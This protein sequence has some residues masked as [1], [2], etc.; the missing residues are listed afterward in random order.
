M[1]RLLGIDIEKTVVRT[2]IVRTAYRKTFVEAIG[3]A[4]IEEHG[5]VEAALRAALLGA[6]RPDACAVALSGERTLYRRIDL[7]AAAAKELE[8]VLGFEIE[9]TVPFEMTDA[10]FDHRLLR[11]AANS[12]VIPVLA[13]IARVEDVREPIR[14]VKEAL[15]MEPERVG[16]GPL[17]LADL[18]SLVPEL[19]TAPPELMVLP[20]DG[21][22]TIAIMDLADA[23]SDVAF[24]VGG[25]PT[26]V[27]TVSRGTMGLPGTAYALAR[28][29][30]QTFSAYRAVGG[31]TPVVLYLVG[32]GSGLGGAETFLAN[33]LGVPVRPLPAPRIE[34]LSAEHAAA[35]P[36]FAKALGL[37]LG[38]SG[39]SRGLDLRQGPLEAQRSYPFLREKIPLLSGLFAVI[40]AS[41]G[42]SIVAEMQSLDAEH[43]RLVAELQATTEAVLGEGTDDPERARR[44]LDGD[45]LTAEEDPMPR[46]DA[47]DVMVALAE[48]VPKETV[49]DLVELDLTKNH[50]T[51]QGTVP[52]IPD[53]QPIAD[54]LKEH[55]CFKDVKV[56]R[57]SQFGQGKQKYTLELEV[58]C[59]DKKKKA[60]TTDAAPASSTKEEA[61]K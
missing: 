44:L 42:F 7:P 11:R 48:A 15:G 46:A 28:E 51:I 56:P 55:K 50:V 14:I 13:A 9:A 47:F 30:R 49:H 40:L 59:D 60:K 25:E 20:A 18:A 41:F 2:A 17:P 21:P 38:L 8:N 24:L 1:S 6:A 12:P 26:F 45:G 4:R 29:L 5:S 32:G 53:V 27:R 39:R 57:T 22:P 54:K 36:R 34:G 35:L 37:A 10:V 58:R 19:E 61:D 33:E 31:A 16:T 3:E 43:E 23:T 52:T